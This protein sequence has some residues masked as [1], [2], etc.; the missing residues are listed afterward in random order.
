M[1]NITSSLTL[2]NVRFSDNEA[3]DGGGM[4]NASSS[5]TLNRV[6]F[7]GNTA[8]YE[9]G[10]GMYN[11]ESSPTLDNVTFSGNAAD[12]FGVWDSTRYFQ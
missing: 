7:A 3:D 9:N 11:S 1:K 2:V 10:G 5:P 8:S 4:Y 6:T 12:N